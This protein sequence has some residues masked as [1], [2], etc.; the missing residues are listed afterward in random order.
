M[1]LKLEEVKSLQEDAPTH[2]NYVDKVGERYGK[3]TVVFYAGRST[4]GNKHQFAC[5]C[6]CGSYSVVST[7]NLRKGGKTNSCGCIRQDLNSYVDPKD[8]ERRVSRLEELTPYKVVDS[9][10]GASDRHKWT[11]LCEKHGTFKAVWSNVV[12]KGTKC[13]SCACL[14]RGFNQMIPG[15]FY[16]NLLT[17]DNDPVALKYGIT[18]S[19]PEKRLTWLSFG[20]DLEITNVFS[21]KFVLGADALEMENLFKKTFGGRHLTKQE[22]ANGFT[23]TIPSELLETALIWVNNYSNSASTTN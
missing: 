12:V 18:N 9:N 4:K 17:K 3:L 7:L 8:I 22:L 21:N 15:H 11:L 23:E 19:T 5:L 2:F 13:P 1:K 20:T 6:D 10:Q 14:S 16:L